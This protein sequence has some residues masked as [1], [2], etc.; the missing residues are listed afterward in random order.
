MDKLIT[1][2]QETKS[3]TVTEIGGKEDKVNTISN[4]RAVNSKT[5]EAKAVEEIATADLVSP[6]ERKQIRSHTQ[7]KSRLPVPLAPT[8][9]NSSPRSLAKPST[10]VQTLPRLP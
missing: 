2:L 4:Y 10:N 6:L 8:S 9:S 1:Q 7:P 3:Y 5:D